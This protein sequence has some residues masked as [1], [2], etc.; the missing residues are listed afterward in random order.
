MPTAQRPVALPA[1]PAA[2]AVVPGA[3]ARR[4]LPAG[5]VKWSRTWLDGK[6]LP[7]TGD[8]EVPVDGNDR[9]TEHL[10]YTCK[11]HIEVDGVK[12]PCDQQQWALPDEPVKFCPDHGCALDAADKPQRAPLLPWPAMWQ[13]VEPSARGLYLLGVSVAAGAVLQQAQVPSW[14]AL[15]ATPALAVGAYAGA[16][17]WLARRRPNVREDTRRRRARAVG[18]AATAGG[19]AT[20]AMAATDPATWP[21][22]VAWALAGVADVVAVVPWWRYLAEQRNRPAPEPPPAEV[23]VEHK[24]SPDE[25]D[26]AEAARIW[27]E[28]VAHPGTRLDVA[29]WQRIACGWQAVV[30]ATKRGALNNLG[31][32]AMKATIRRVAG[33]YNVPK[34]AV[35]WIEEYED[36]PNLALLLVQPNNPLKE[37][38]IWRGPESIRIERNRIVAEVG[39]LIDGTPMDEVLFRVGQGVFGA[40]TLGSTGSGKSERLRLKLV[41]ER[42]ASYLDPATG[43]RRGLYLSFLHDPKRLEAFAEFRNAVHGYGITRDDAHLM[44][45]AFTREM[46]RRYDFLATLKWTDAKGRPRAGGVP[47]N[48]LVHGPILSVIWDEF[49]ALAGDAEFV[50]KLETLARYVRACAMRNE[51][52]SHMGT[53]GDT[54][55]QALRDMVAG[56]R[57]TLLRTTSGLNA[58]LA[59]GGQLTGDPRGLPRE[60]G[61]CLVAD[62]ETATMMGRH[63]YIPNDDA[64][65][66]LGGRSLYDW[67]FDDHNQP[68]GY[69]AVIP[70]E[71]A[72]AFGAEFMEWMAAGRSE[73]GRESRLWAP[74]QPVP[75]A[76][77]LSSLDA[78]RRILFDAPAPISR[79]QII[80]SPL[81][82]FGVTSTL[83]AALN[84][85]QAATPPWIVR[86]GGGRATTFELTPAAREEYGARLAE[87]VAE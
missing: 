78:L 30:E 25:I 8:H 36:S 10:R 63:G 44:V 41:I 38:Q 35:T 54:G 81:W 69:P 48:P 87:A 86:H 82:R 62:G 73:A 77:D 51:L 7:Q 80:A 6:G 50:K 24:P 15:A 21:G 19:V 46:V 70:P 28:H 40:L 11:G 5:A 57:A 55:S 58:A 13:A 3:G 29:R 20:T 71:T 23:V 84:K 4:P 34:S 53:L 43:Q 56:G 22:R 60:P 72:E 37:P 31:G 66:R 16:R 79:D 67:L 26:A 2:P 1:R 45:D 42:W 12:Q 61:M 18:Y 17:Q 39:R 65:D 76:D 52:A 9:R 49:H 85:G 83:T 32:D 75:S 68:I 59:T 27:A 64:A 33:A 47:W 74:T 14:S